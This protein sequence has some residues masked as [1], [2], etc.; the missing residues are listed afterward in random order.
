MD[1]QISGF[2]RFM[3]SAAG[4]WLRIIAGAVI[5]F[6]GWSMHSGTGTIVMLIGLVPIAAGA[7]DFCLIAPLLHAPFWGRDIRRSANV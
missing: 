6:W 4:R 3:A 1:F 5:I 2:A 7:F